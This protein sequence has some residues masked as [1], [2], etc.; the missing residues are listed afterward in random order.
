[1]NKKKAID[2]KAFQREYKKKKSILSPFIRNIH[3][4]KIKGLKSKIK[5][6]SEEV[7]KEI[8]CTTCANCCKSMTP[9][10]TKADIKRVASHLQ[11]GQQ[12]FIAR[13]LEKDDE[14]KDWVNR[15]RPCQFLGADNLCTIYEVR[16]YDCKGFPHLKHTRWMDQREVFETNMEYCPA[17]LRMVEIMFEKVTEKSVTHR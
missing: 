1:M 10:F 9:T 12:E 15:K 16:P 11:I 2:I 13:Y 4:R 3:R 8:D 17:T 14:G 6:T 7:W 5:S